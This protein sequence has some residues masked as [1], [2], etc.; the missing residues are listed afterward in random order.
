MFKLG[1]MQPPNLYMSKLKL[2][3]FKCMKIR[4]TASPF[5]DFSVNF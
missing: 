4:R 1:F 2:R 5:R 3:K